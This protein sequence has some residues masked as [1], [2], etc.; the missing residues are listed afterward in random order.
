M[1]K[2][3]RRRRASAPS[4]KKKA[5]DKK[6]IV[7]KIVNEVHSCRLKNKTTIGCSTGEK[8][9]NCAGGQVL[10]IQ[11]VNND[12][13]RRSKQFADGPYPFQNEAENIR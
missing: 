9:L 4:L 11:K 2:W 5:I 6:M 12:N 3:R 8:V 7:I 10:S 13:K 1:Q